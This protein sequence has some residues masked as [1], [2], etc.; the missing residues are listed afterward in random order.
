MVLC[1]LYLVFAPFADH[2]LESCIGVLFILSGLLFYF[3]FVKYQ[4]LPNT[5]IVKYGKYF[6]R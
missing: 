5:W 6:F 1:S 4:I 2:P 3:A